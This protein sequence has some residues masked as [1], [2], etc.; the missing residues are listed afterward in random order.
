MRRLVYLPFSLLVFLLSVWQAVALPTVLASRG[1]WFNQ[2]QRQKKN[3]FKVKM[4]FFLF[5]LY[6]TLLHRRHCVGGCL[7]RTQDCCNFGVD[8]QTL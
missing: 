2:R 5:L 1:W 7:D 8:C 4:D 3:F 6:S